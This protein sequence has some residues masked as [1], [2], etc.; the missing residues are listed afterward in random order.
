MRT[1]WLLLGILALG[2]EAQGVDAPTTSTQSVNQAAV[3]QVAPLA[4]A[5]AAR[6]LAR[7]DASRL[8]LGPLEPVEAAPA[9]D[10]RAALAAL[11][12]ATGGEFKVEWFE[13]SWQASDGSYQALLDARSGRLSVTGPE[14]YDAGLKPVSDDELLERGTALLR[15][16]APDLPKELVLKHLGGTLRY[17][18]DDVPAEKQNS[19]ERLGS[20]VFAIRELGGLPVAGNRLVASYLND[21]RLMGV[22]GVWPA[23]DL[24]R[25]R[26]RSDMRQDE[27]VAKAVALL[28]EHGVNPDREEP[29]VLESFYE[30]RPDA[31][32]WVAVLRASALVVSYNGEDEPGR[33]E[34]HDFDI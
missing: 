31:N 7:I 13:S 30:L 16:F 33:R 21:S 17:V 5:I 29:I 24:A 19:E 27:V 12:D 34:R 28:V 32:G 8:A 25:S 1:G 18:A 2:C 20:K 14:A 6:L 23:I 9:F 3:D 15:G 10:E 22:R 26:L 11:H 4:D